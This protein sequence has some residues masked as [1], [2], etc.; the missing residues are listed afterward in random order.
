MYFTTICFKKDI[1][2]VFF[3]FFDFIY[4]WFLFFDLSYL[5]TSTLFDLLFPYVLLILILDTS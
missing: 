3:Y 1:K 2:N 5:K 4:F